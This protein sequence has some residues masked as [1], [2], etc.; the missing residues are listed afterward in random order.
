MTFPRVG[1]GTDLS[2]LMRLWP[3]SSMLLAFRLRSTSI[4]SLRRVH[5]L[6][7]LIAAVAV[8]GTAHAGGLL[9]EEITSYDQLKNAA[10][11]LAWA[12]FKPQ[13]QLP[14]ALANL[15]YDALRL[16]A[17]RTNKSIILN[18]NQSYRLEFFHKG[19][20]S[21]D[22]VTVNLI[23]R[24]EEFP[25]PFASNFFDYRGRMSTLKVPRDL[26]FAGFRIAGKFPQRNDL[27]EIITF[28]GAS[29]FRARGEQHTYGS[30]A[31]GLA[32]NCGMPK[33]EE[34]PI[35]REFW[36]VDD[37]NPEETV[38]IYAL[39]DSPSL[40]GAYKFTLIPGLERTDLDITATVY[41]R[42]TPEKVGFAPLT[43]MWMW[44]DGLK[45][46]AGDHRPEVHDAD[47]MLVHM[48]DGKWMWRVLGR[49]DYPSLM[50]FECD[51]IR[52]FGL[53][54]RDID[55]NHYLDQEAKYHARPSLWIEPKSDWGPGHIELLE[56]D[57]HHE[58]IDNIAAWW[59]T[60]QEL[61]PQRPYE[62]AY[63]VSFCTQPP[64]EHRLAK[65]TGFRTNR[66]QPGKIGLEIDFS[67]PGL[68]ARPANEP[69]T[70]AVQS[71]RGKI[72]VRGCEKSASGIWTAKME[73]EPTGEGPI[74][75]TVVLKDK[76]QDVSETWKHLCPLTPPPVSLPPWRVQDA[77]SQEKMP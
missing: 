48:K 33:A 20:V 56:L 45:G 14:E 68:S 71:V 44:G 1:P 32:V 27:Q 39:M 49:L 61:G 73:V 15:N 76:E 66:D 51:G 70:L 7:M 2:S 36:I 64:V 31:R 67:G 43:S 6:V 21:K 12:E 75:I 24:G 3:S 42:Q 41:F 4:F 62:L 23:S 28:L 37:Q 55:P 18:G 29:Y 13:P 59:V 38:D 5:Q 25:V 9:E 47:G 22:D 10:Q 60:H 52:G 34:F 8:C 50:K 30:S 53:L 26:G 35:F 19:Y 77:A 11:R 72:N 69:P 16:V 65:S 46:P 40:T 58:G 74:E 17:F 54:Q 63:R 57:A